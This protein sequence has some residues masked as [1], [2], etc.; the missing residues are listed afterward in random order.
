VAQFPSMK[1]RELL[2]HLARKP[3]SYV[4]DPNRS[5]KGSH[6]TLVS[7]IFGEVLLGFH[8]RADVAPG[9]VRK[10]FVRD[11]GLSQEDA[12]RHLRGKLTDKDASRY[13]RDHR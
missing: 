5:R 10:V 13:A 8:D 2:R 1:G 4:E 3:L 11:V 12:L 6:R 7:P 9:M